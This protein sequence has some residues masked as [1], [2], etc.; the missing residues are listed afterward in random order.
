MN[1]KK[2]L[3]VQKFIGDTAKEDELKEYYKN[4]GA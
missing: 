1:Y 2:T 3:A 4:G